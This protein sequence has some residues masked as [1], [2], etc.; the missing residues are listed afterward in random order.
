MT[1]GALTESSSILTVA[2]VDHVPQAVAT[3]RSAR[4]QGMKSS[5]Y[6]FAVDAITETVADLRRTL[7]DDAAWIRV[8]GP[9]D[10][11][12]ERV[13][14]LG[15]FDR[16]NATELCCLAKYVGVSH[17]LRDSLA[18]EVC[19][20][21]DGDMLFLGDVHESVEEMGGSAILLTPHLIGPSSDDVEYD[22][23]TH[24]WMNAGFLAFRR[25]HPGTRGVLDWL[26]DRIS[27]RGFFA[28]RYG[29]SCD[30]T[31][32]SALP[33]LFRDLTSVSSHLGLNVGY[34]NLSERP[35]TRSGKAILAGGSSLLLFHFSGF[36]WK[37]SNRLSKHSEFTVPSGSTLEELCRVY[38]AE[39]DSVAGLKAGV[40]GLGTFAC[41]TADLDERIQIGSIQSGVNIA[42]PTTNIG[43]FSR[44][45]GKMDSILRKTVI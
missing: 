41:S 39:L 32:V 18:G 36:E 8:F 4:R 6:L 9:N 5:F 31:W 22:I 19:I 45:V 2:T 20:Y 38:Q 33:V 44:L 23:M 11:G 24:G 21:V 15:V 16:Y 37:R 14:F 26:I 35:L 17:V 29:L 34:W 7:R 28:P 42:M 25:H 13:G 43:L 40:E 1:K 12:P 10:L 27:R 30:Q 3:L